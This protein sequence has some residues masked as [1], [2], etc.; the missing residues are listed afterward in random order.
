L[1]AGCWVLEAG[2]SMLDTGP[3]E[4]HDPS[5][6]SLSIKKHLQQLRDEDEQSGHSG[7][8]G[9]KKHAGGGGIFGFAGQLMVFRGNQIGE[10]FD[11]GIQGFGGK[12]HHHAQGDDRPFGCRQPKEQPRDKNGAGCREMDAGIG[13]GSQKIGDALEGIFKTFETFV[14]HGFDGL[15]SAVEV[16]TMPVGLPFRLLI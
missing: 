3:G 8:Y 6:G 11:G 7:A 14:E 1:G 2:G 12:D 5:I 15:W 4:T 9:G 10:V 16:P 13:L